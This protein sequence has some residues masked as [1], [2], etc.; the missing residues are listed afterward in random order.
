MAR[1]AA[2]IQAR[3]GSSRLP[4]KVR[5]ELAGQS[6]LGHV[7]RRAMAI[8]RVDVVCLATTDLAPD[9]DLA[10]AAA[11]YGAEVFRG[12]SDDVLGR[13]L[14]AA[15]QLD[16]DVVMRITCD[17]PVIDPE[18]CNKVLELRANTNADYAANVTPPDWP[19]GLDCEAFTTNV[20]ERAAAQAQ[21][22]DEREHVTIWIRQHPDIHREDLAGPGGAAAR[23]RWTLDYPEDLMFFRELFRY[24]PSPPAMPGWR[25]ILAV[26]EKHPNIAAINAKRIDPSRRSA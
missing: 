3:S 22:P 10:D 12:S 14:G 6:V 16:A 8:E 25:E 17:C 5:E 1:T 20:L 7:L 21:K 13:Y 2:I 4:G 23:Q 19:H 26:V 18:V 11:R 9:D 15:R 24:L